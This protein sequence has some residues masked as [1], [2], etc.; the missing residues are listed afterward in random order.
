PAWLSADRAYLEGAC[1]TED[2][3][4]AVA[5]WCRLEARL[6]ARGKKVQLLTTNRPGQIAYWTNRGRH[7]DKPAVIED[8]AEFADSWRSWWTHL[9]PE[10][11][12][13]D[14][15]LRR[16]GAREDEDWMELRK[17]GR[18]GFEMIL[19]SMSWWFSAAEPGTE[20]NEWESALEDV[21]WV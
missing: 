12:A 21:N 15:P 14:W 1:E 3:A 20:R 11:R 18:N 7:F 8:V 5:N 17:G 10:W 19:V 6:G 13:G 16:T 4:R 2:W 9:Q